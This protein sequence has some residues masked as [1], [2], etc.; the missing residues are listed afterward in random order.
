[1]ARYAYPRT[2]VAVHTDRQ[3]LIMA[4]DIVAFNHNRGDAPGTI[5]DKLIGSMAG[6]GKH[7]RTDPS[8]TSRAWGFYFTTLYGRKA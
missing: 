8:D 7:R 6:E 5:I 4:R 1:M 2:V 3:A